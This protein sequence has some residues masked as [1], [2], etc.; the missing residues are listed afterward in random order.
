MIIFTESELKQYVQLNLEAISIIEEAFT[1]L[2]GNEVV[3]PPIMRVDIHDENGEVD[4]K[5]AYIKGK[6]M[7]AIK[8]SS[9]FFNNYKLGLPS[10][11]GL[12][13]LISTK[14][15]V[16]QALLLDNGYLTD[17]RTAAAGAIAAKYLSRDHIETV[18]VIGAGGQA[19]FQ[20]RA[21]KLVRNFKKV[22]VYSRSIERAKRYAKDMSEELGIDVVVA[23]SAETVVRNSDTVITTTP[24]KEPI[25]KAEWLHPGLHI[26]AMGS[27]AEHK[28]ELEA[29][30][31]VRADKLVCDTKEQCA[32]LGELHHALDQGVLTIHSPIVE[33]GQLTSGQC[34]GREN[35]EQITVCDL[36]GTGVQDTAIALFAYHEMKKR[37]LGLK[38]ENQVALLKQ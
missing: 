9:G 12:M 21:L 32:R 34:I 5:T 15:G 35:E 13:M 11:N 31:L 23:D 8:V 24:S 33:L 17:V 18:G 29:E 19:R 20:V 28:Q 10:G 16:P 7:F 37:N 25:V 3:M 36:T 1:K 2:A 6:E 27:D 22:L 38:V 30:V 14:T 4:V 26:T